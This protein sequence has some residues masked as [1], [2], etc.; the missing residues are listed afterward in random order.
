MVVVKHSFSMKKEIVTHLMFVSQF[1]TH[2]R[3]LGFPRLE[4]ISPEGAKDASKEPSRNIRT[5]DG[6]LAS[7]GRVVNSFRQE[8]KATEAMHLSLHQE[9]EIDQGLSW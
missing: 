7:R 9:V 8:K 4:G 2:I 3:P 1:G 5:W 6:R